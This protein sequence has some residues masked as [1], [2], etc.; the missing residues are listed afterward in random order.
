MKTHASKV[1]RQP[2]ER[3]N[4][5]QAVLHA[6]HK[7]TGDTSVPIVDLKA[8][9]GGR[10]PEGICGA[11]HTACLIAPDHAKTL[12]SAF[13]ERLGSIY[14]KELRAA[15]N[16]RCIACVAEAAELLDATTCRKRSITV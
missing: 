6:W 8:F 10:A 9:G 1:F 14:C 5:A 11:L 12:K 13:A 2:P 15:G 3:L 4:C 7:I 16:H